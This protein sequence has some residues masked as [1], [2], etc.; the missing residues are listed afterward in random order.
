MLTFLPYMLFLLLMDLTLLPGSYLVYS[1]ISSAIFVNWKGKEWNKNFI[2][3]RGFCKR[4]C[5][6]TA[7][8]LLYLSKI[9]FCTI[10]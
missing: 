4:I 8:G 10:F 9:L 3:K 6:L 1:V 7:C 2:K 5:I